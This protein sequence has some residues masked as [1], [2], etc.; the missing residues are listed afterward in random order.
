MHTY[1][2]YTQVTHTNR[3]SWRMFLPLTPAAPIP[4]SATQGS[5][6]H[7]ARPFACHCD[8]EDKAA[9]ALSRYG[10]KAEEGGVGWGLFVTCG[11]VSECFSRQ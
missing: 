2:H 10:K 9:A 7:D 4:V 8:I 3:L 11:Y 1:I 5:G 6:R